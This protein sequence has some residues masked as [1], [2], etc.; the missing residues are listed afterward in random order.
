LRLSGM[1]GDS[2][3]EPLL[4]ACRHWFDGGPQCHAR[5]PVGVKQPP[6]TL[7]FAL[8]R[9]ALIDAAVRVHQALPRHLHAPRATK[10]QLLGCRA[11]SGARLDAAPTAGDAAVTAWCGCERGEGV[12]LTAYGSAIR[13]GGLVRPDRDGWPTYGRTTPS[14]RPLWWCITSSAASR[15]RTRASAASRRCVG[16]GWRGW[17]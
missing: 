17:D 12:S 8:L 4:S 14:A 13:A 5:V 1:C 7:R 3:P 15:M 10:H 2:H 6:A 16:G 9:Q 11:L